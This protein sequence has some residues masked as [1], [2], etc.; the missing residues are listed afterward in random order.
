MGTGRVEKGPF[1]PIRGD[2]LSRK[3]IAQLLTL[4]YLGIERYKIHGSPDDVTIFCDNFDYLQK[5]RHQIIGD[6]HDI[7]GSGRGFQDTNGRIATGY[8]PWRYQA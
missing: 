6:R 4:R 8:D 3:P 7:I 2:C 5:A 1:G